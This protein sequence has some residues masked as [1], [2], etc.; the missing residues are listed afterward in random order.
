MNGQL[1]LI[2]LGPGAAGLQA[3]DATAALTAASDL[4]GYGPYLDRVATGPHQTRHPTD[5]RV[6]LERARHALALAEHGRRV[7]VVSS[8]DAGVFAMASEVF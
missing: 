4:V 1:T 8:G 6:E 5:N 3:P 7:A 2:G